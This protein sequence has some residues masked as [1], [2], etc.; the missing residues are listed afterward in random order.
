MTAKTPPRLIAYIVAPSGQ[1]GGGMGRVKDYILASGGDAAGRV[2][3]EPLVTRD[4]RGFKASLGLTVKAVAA[5]WKAHLSGRLAL[6]HVNLG[7]KA[8]AVRKGVVAVL[9]RA[10]GARVVVHLHAVHLEPAWRKG[11]AITRWLIALPFRV[12]STNIVL[13]EVWRRWLVND[14][15]VAPGRVDVLANGVPAP[16]YAP[17]DHRASRDKVKLLFLGN[18]LERKGVADLIAALARLSPDLPAWTAT[19]AGGGDIDRYR[20]LGFQIGSISPGGWT[21]RGP[22]RCWPRRT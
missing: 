7:D 13:G 2:V 20:A 12:A 10:L 8:S 5:V 21:N 1:A 22:R 15:G 9:G 11:G 17:R 16:P 3:F 6:V 4:D 14:M 18:L 19:L